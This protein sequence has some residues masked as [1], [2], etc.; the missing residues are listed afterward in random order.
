MATLNHAKDNRLGAE[1]PKQYE[2]NGL[3]G[4]ILVFR[5]LEPPIDDFASSFYPPPPPDALLHRPSALFFSVIF[6][7]AHLSLLNEPGE[8]SNLLPRGSLCLLSYPLLSLVHPF[9]SRCNGTVDATER[10]A[11]GLSNGHLGGP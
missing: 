7:A 3:R 6:L 10:G 11:P 5:F 1:R 8:T 4:R 9:F 2:T